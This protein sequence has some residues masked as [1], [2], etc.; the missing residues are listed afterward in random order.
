M[1]DFALQA[2]NT[3]SNLPVRRTIRS[4]IRSSASLPTVRSVTRSTV[5]RLMSVFIYCNMWSTSLN[6][7]VFL[8]RLVGQ[9]PEKTSVQLRLK[10]S[11][12]DESDL[13][14]SML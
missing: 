11:A 1:S 4:E 10:R 5:S 6:F 8:I 3:T 2:Q 9:T 13:R 14:T 7:H 12:D